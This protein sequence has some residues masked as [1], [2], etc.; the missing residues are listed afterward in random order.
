MADF[1][2]I[3]AHV[4]SD[5]RNALQEEFRDLESRFARG[6]WDSANLSGGR[7]A[8]AILRFL[9][10]KQSAGTYT[11][12]GKE[13]ARSSIL[14]KVR[15]DTKVPEGLRF[16]VARITELL[17]DLRNKR[18]VAHLGSAPD[19]KE[20]DARLVMASAS[21]IMAEVVR[22]ES[23]AGAQEAQ[24]IIDRLNR[25]RI[26]L[27]EEIGNDLVVLATDLP[28]AKRVLV[29]LYKVSPEAMEFEKLRSAVGYENKT[30]FGAIVKKHANE[31]MIHLNGDSARI[32]T[33]GIAW[34][35]SN[36]DME[37]KL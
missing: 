17:M 7:F 2:T 5:I 23:R 16:L 35:E 24:L 19:V 4:P 30:R 15:N 8:E 12:I 1:A 22:E 31:R 27:V 20:T 25:R 14:S 37:L 9:E 11:P 10:W 32:T 33:K 21:W 18:D 29:A 36:I 28:A 6:D 34:V 26:P 3:L 13:L